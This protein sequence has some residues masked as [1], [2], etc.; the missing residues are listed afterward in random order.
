MITYAGLEIVIL[1]SRDVMGQGALDSSSVDN[2]AEPVVRS[3][4]YG[5]LKLRKEGTD[6]LGVTRSNEYMHRLVAVGHDGDE[7][8]G[9]EQPHHKP[10]L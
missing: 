9:N 7:A 3:I 5:W 8:S 1:H 4:E 2:H 6:V 10:L